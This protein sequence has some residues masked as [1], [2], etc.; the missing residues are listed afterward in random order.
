MDNKKKRL[1]F[2]RVAGLVIAVVFICFGGFRGEM[3]IVL[4]KAITI[5]FECIGLG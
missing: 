4:N 2:L 5:C 3:N 1:L